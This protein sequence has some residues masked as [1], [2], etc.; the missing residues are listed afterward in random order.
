M[1]YNK[2]VKNITTQE[3]IFDK[4]EIKNEKG[5]KEGYEEIK[6][7]KEQEIIY[8]NLI[9]FI[10]SDK[11]RELLLVGYAGTGKTTMVAKFI[12][13][14]I[15]T[16]LCNKIVMAAPTHKAVNIAKSKLIN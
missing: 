8:K 13:D 9:E 1:S 2:N 6:L 10:K 14:L 11:S 7:T 15:K 5:V 12:N 16:K 3:I 4:K